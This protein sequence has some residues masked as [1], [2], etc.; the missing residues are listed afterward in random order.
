MASTSSMKMMAGAFSLAILKT[1][2]TMRGPCK[3]DSDQALQLNC[4][5]WACYSI[6]V[7]AVRTY[8][9]VLLLVARCHLKKYACVC[10]QM[11]S[12]SKIDTYTATC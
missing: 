1:S 2:R 4:K 11:L 6:K 7:T 3:A 10:A 5:K 12:S 8:R 9:K